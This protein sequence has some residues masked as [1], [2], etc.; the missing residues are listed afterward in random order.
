LF[1][2][3]PTVKRLA[4][5]CLLSISILSA[6]ASTAPQ[7][8]STTPPSE[9][10]ADEPPAGLGRR[11]DAA[12]LGPY[13]A[14]QPLV[15]LAHKSAEYSASVNSWLLEGPTEIGLVDAQMLV[16]EAE[17]LVELLRS[18]NKKL[19]WVW[20][21]HA[22]PDHYAGL[23]VIA[24]AF[25]GVPLLA[26]P[27]TAQKAPELR[28]KFDEPLQKFFP[29]LLAPAAALTPYADTSLRVD[30]V[31][32]E[33][34]TFTG[35]EHELSTAL[36]VRAQQA[37]IIADLVYNE[38]HPWLNELDVDTLLTHVDTLAAMQGVE[39]FYPGHGEPF[40]KEF[41]PVYTKYVHDFLAEL[42]HASDSKD[43]V[44]R[45]WRRYRDWRTLAG[46][47]FSATA[48]IEARNA[49]AAGT[50]EPTRPSAP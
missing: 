30:G 9:T 17:A 10:A 33:I 5:L 7:P 2:E 18:R 4:T 3:R 42:E 1:V 48:H 50:S 13:E 31:E 29:G 22:H 40:G 14:G 45:T 25:P 49:A 38:V 37:M 28:A 26:H 36:F 19:A 8:S 41:L 47:R 21:T 43:L 12:T 23:Q 15:L 27:E 6:C 24:D 16:P 32:I 46:L 20:V 39:T 34:L 11:D 44:A 35:G